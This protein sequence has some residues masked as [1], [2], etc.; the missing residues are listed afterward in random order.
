LSNG[1]KTGRPLILILFVVAVRIIAA[2]NAYYRAFARNYR[3]G[4]QQQLNAVGE[5]KSTDLARSLTS[6]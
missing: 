4:I 6:P 5:L 3:I 2:G 1:R